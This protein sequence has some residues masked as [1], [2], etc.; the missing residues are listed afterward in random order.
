[1]RAMLRTLV[2]EPL[3]RARTEAAYVATARRVFT[4]GATRNAR[5]PAG[6]RVV[7][8]DV[9]DVR[10]EWVLE[11]RAA[12]SEAAILY[13]H[14]GAYV[15]SGPLAYRA[16]A[17]ALTRR[18]G[19]PVFV[20]DYR[21]AP[22][23]P[24]P[25]ALDDAVAAYRALRRRLRA[26]DIVLA[27]DS[28][29]GNLALATLLRLRA[30]PDG[31]L[32]VAGVAVFSP[33]TDLT[34]SG[35]SVALNAQ[36]DDVIPPPGGVDP[37]TIYARGAERTDPLVSPLFGSYAGGPPILAFASTI[38]ILRD[39]AVRLVKSVRREGVDATLVLE[40]D[41]PHVWP[42][43]GALVP[44]SRRALTIVATFIAR[45]RTLGESS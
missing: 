15:A 12:T 1:M 7:P 28:A 42:V 18:T 35:D 9:R 40:P 32:P 33:W 16:F 25:A 31:P 26:T 5:V 24:F 38:E 30:G 39:D 6:I 4:L 3:A 23:H 22:E 37:A 41:M 14:G 8:I 2:R 29:G 34:G 27:G 17:I 43:F 36:S 21:L 19:I 10:G 13:L 11:R 44:E 20:L 45:A